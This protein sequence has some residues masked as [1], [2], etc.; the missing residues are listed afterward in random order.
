MAVLGY[1]DL[2]GELAVIQKKMIPLLKVFRAYL[3]IDLHLAQKIVDK[4]LEQLS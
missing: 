2:E 4:E 3:W 1:L